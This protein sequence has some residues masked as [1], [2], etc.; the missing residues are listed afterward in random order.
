MMITNRERILSKIKSNLGK[1][2]D[3]AKIDIDILEARLKGSMPSL[4]PKRGIIQQDKLLEKFESSARGVAS[5]VS[6]IDDLAEIPKE[7]KYYLTQNNIASK[8][9]VLPNKELDSIDWN[10]Y[11][12]LEV[13]KK[14]PDEKDETVFVSSYVAIAETGTIVQLSSSENPITSHFLPDNSIVLVKAS[15]IVAAAED[16]F[17]VMRKEI[18]SIPRTITLISG[19]SRTGDIALNIELGAHGPRK[20]HLL[21]WND[22][23]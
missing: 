7:V 5:S 10:K 4:I 20:V 6:I 22:T 14:F 17:K 15:R 8:I 13:T 9:V 16:A 3:R 21:I 12:T 11:P 19:P 23:K 2:K 1:E 18:N